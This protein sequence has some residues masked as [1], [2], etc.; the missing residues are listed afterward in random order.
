M[1]RGYLLVDIVWTEQPSI[2]T[3]TAVRSYKVEVIV[4]PKIGFDRDKASDEALR[5]AV[6]EFIPEQVRDATDVSIIVEV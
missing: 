6:V 5:A 2:A 1:S 3:F 4:R